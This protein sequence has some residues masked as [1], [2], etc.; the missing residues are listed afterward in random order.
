MSKLTKITRSILDLLR[1]PDLTENENGQLRV[2]L[3][4][5]RRVADPR[6]LLIDRI[7]DQTTLDEMLVRVRLIKERFNESN[8]VILGN[9]PRY[10]DDPEAAAPEQRM[11]G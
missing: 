6:R 2:T 7:E 1:R 4:F 3:K 11:A 8:I 9:R 10:E 5:I